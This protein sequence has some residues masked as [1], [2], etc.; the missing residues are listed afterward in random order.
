[1]EMSDFQKAFLS[2]GTG[3]T[4][5]TQKEFDDALA[6]AKAEIMTVAID[7]TKAAIQ[8]E[9]DECAKIAENFVKT[10]QVDDANICRDIAHAI[11]NRMI[12]S[13]SDL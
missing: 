2:R 12:S 5:F 13:Q 6:V 11:R 8:I 9:R 1:M 4:L 10:I 7:T 3:Q